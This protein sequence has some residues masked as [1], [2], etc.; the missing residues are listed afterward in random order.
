MSR[1]GKQP[2]AI[3]SGVE[4]SVKDNTITV[5]GKNGQLEQTFDTRNVSISSLEREASPGHARPLPGPGAKHGRR[6][7]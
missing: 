1:V 2:V 5:K 3:P 7:D 6:C 4:V